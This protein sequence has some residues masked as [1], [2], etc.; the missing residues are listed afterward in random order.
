MKAR[1][2]N[3][4]AMM[5]KEERRKRRERRGEG[6]G[7]KSRTRLIRIII[8][9]MVLGLS[10]KPVYAC[11]PAPMTPWFTTTVSLLSTNL[12]SDIR[13]I[14]KGG[15]L[16]LQNHSQVSL[17]IL[18]DESYANDKDVFEIASGEASALRDELLGMYPGTKEALWISSSDS[19]RFGRKEIQTFNQYADNRPAN[20]VIPQ[21]QLVMLRAE[22]YQQVFH[23]QL[24]VEYELNQRYDPHSVS[25]WN[26]ACQPAI[27]LLFGW[28]NLWCLIVAA[29]LMIFVLVALVAQRGHHTG[30]ATDTEIGT[31]QGGGPCR[32]APSCSGEA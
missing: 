9:T 29:G 25:A 27:E 7:K 3:G 15:V 2:G 14:E 1:K 6:I 5:A 21:P 32:H 31:R 10:T 12:P 20:V 4:E 13:F 17:S 28:M 19:H 24:R 18:V 8:S 11:S 23:I 16:T 30:D 26:T 22:L